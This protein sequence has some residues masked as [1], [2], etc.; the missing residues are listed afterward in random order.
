MRRNFLLKGDQSTNG[1]T[2][3]EGDPT[4]TCDGIP[5]AFHGAKVYCPECKSTGAIV[6]SGPTLS[7]TNEKG[8]QQALEGDLCVCKCEP[9]PRMLASRRDTFLDLSVEQL[10]QQGY[11]ASGRRQP[12]T[13]PTQRGRLVFKSRDGFS[14]AGLRCRA[15]FSDGSS[16]DGV[17]DG[18]NRLVFDDVSALDCRHLRVMAAAPVHGSMCDSFLDAIAR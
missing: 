7:M 17:F 11:D 1:G 15:Y 2:V 5:V 12:P 18:Q 6:G 9:P 13:A 14:V 4:F 10:T 3:L 16:A 8:Q